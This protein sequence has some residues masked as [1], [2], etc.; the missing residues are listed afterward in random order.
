MRSPTQCTRHALPEL[1]THGGVQD[2]INGKIDGLG[3]VGYDYSRSEWVQGSAAMANDLTP[4]GQEHGGADKE[5]KEADYANEDDSDLGCRIS[6][7]ASMKAMIDLVYQAAV[8]IY[9]ND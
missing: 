2:K 5:Q 7:R 3:E 6:M 8:A 4:E 9:E 1:L